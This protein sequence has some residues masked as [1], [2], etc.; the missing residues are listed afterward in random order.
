M[1]QT[2]T[3]NETDRSSLVQRQN[4]EWAKS[5]YLGEVA[6]GRLQVDD[7]AGTI[8]IPAHKE[9]NVEQ[10]LSD[11]PRIFTGFTRSRKIRRG[12]TYTVGASREIDV[13]TVDGNDLLKRLV[14]RQGRPAET[15]GERIEWLLD[16]WLP[17]VFDFG[18]VTYS[19]IALDKG[20]TRGQ[21]PGDVIAA[22]AKAA[23]FNYYVRW[24]QFAAW[25]LVF[26]DNNT[27]TDDTCELAISNDLADSSAT[28][29]APFQEAELDVDGE[30]VYS[31]AFA[32]HSKHF[33]YR[34]RPATAEAF[35]D[36]DGITEDSLIRTNSTAG[37]DALTFLNQSATEEQTLPVTLKLTA[38]QA[39]LVQAGMRIETRMTHMAPEGW[40]PAI[41]ARNLR[42]RVT[43]PLNT[44]GVY[45]AA[46]DL[47]PQEEF[48]EVAVCEFENT[49]AGTYYP[50][51]GADGFA[52]PV[53]TNIAYY[54]R[55]GLA[56][57]Y[58]GPNPD[59]IGRWHFSYQ[60][61]N[62]SPG[63]SG[64]TD[65]FASGF[66]N[67][68]QFLLV[69][70]GT[71]TIQT[72]QWQGQEQPFTIEIVHVNADGSN[73]I[74]GSDAGVAGQSIEVEVTTADDPACLNVVRLAAD[75]REEG[76]HIGMGW[77]A[78]EWVPV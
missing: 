36:R 72:E 26:R 65:T 52:N 9:V 40:D 35:V 38:A 16:E 1:T 20:T 19:S 28:V 77:S 56:G 18:A 63:G 75:D 50:L 24:S 21:Y 33:V 45:H 7:A 74:V 12:Q 15:I 27:S 62:G 73:E 3:V 46:L 4:V 5:A 25:E 78:A 61:D 39:G 22:M 68:L 13:Q 71:L 55:A 47:V 64:T 34:R 11:F 51:G 41:Y 6:S 30:D 10:D 57:P 37:R 54:I 48:E 44:D 49:P 43:Q 31:G 70:N 17:D 42:K 69:G 53:G 76:V 8:V 29:L 58:S 59:F 2:I 14:I 60:L 32:T 23:N 67:S 66:G